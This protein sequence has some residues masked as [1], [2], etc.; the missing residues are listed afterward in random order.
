MKYRDQNQQTNKSNS[1]GNRDYK[2]KKIQ[3]KKSLL[4]PERWQKITYLFKQEQ[5]TT[6]KGSFKAPK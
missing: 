5:D 3:P 6:K 1:E 4:Y 2:G